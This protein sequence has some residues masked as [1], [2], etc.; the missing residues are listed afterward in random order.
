MTG[1]SERLRVVSI[2]TIKPPQKDELPRGPL[3]LGG[4]MERGGSASG[5]KVYSIIIGDKHKTS[6]FNVYKDTPIFQSV[7]EIMTSE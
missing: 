6:P 1:L 5:P 7:K 2:Y 4:R 3:C